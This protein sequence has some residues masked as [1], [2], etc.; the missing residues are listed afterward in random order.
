MCSSV[1]RRRVRL[2]AGIVSSGNSL[3]YTKEDMD[4]MEQHG[5]SVKEME[6]AAIAWAAHLHACPMFALKAITDI[7]DGAHPCF[8]YCT[9]KP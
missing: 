8:A 6:A 3:D 9:G 4:V 1:M 2:Q 5:A 7:V